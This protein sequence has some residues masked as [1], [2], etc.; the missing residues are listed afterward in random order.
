MRMEAFIRKGLRL[1]ADCVVRIEEDEAAGELT[2][3]LD[4]M[5]WD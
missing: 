1:K 4:R 2:V 5:G 3:Y